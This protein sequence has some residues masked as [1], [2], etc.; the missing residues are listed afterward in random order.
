MSITEVQQLIRRLLPTLATNTALANKEHMDGTCSNGAFNVVLNREQSAH[1]LCQSGIIQHVDALLQ[2]FGPVMIDVKTGLRDAPTSDAQEAHDALEALYTARGFHKT[3]M[4]S[5][6]HPDARDPAF[7]ALFID[8]TSMLLSP[9]KAWVL[10]TY[11][12][13]VD[14]KPGADFPPSVEIKGKPV[15]LSVESL[16][17][18]VARGH[19]E[20]DSS[21]GNDPN[22]N[23][24]YTTY[25]LVSH[26]N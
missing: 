3:G 9:L 24:I 10:G 20:M 19:L 18:G 7:P 1:A 16:T 21:T 5:W 17:L 15:D 6:S 13:H 25:R 14:P 11:F 12:T 22:L 26:P 2:A 8:N 23:A 4:D